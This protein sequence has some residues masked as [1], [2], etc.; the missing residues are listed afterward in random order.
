MFTILHI[1][2]LHRS[3]DDPISNDE[4]IS[5][6]RVDSHRY[7]S[8][9]PSVRRPD[10]IVVSGDL[11]QGV[12]L[13]V[14]NYLDEIRSQ[15]SVAEDFLRRLCDEFLNGDRS[16]IVIVPGNHDVDWNTSRVAMTP[17]VAGK[18][19]NY[20]AAFREDALYRW[21]WRTRQFYEIVDADVYANRLAAF[22][23]F[24]ERFYHNVS[25]IRPLRKD[26]A[27]GLFSLCD[28]RIGVAAFNSCEG[29]DCFAFH[30]SIKRQTIAASHL[31]LGKRAFDLWIGVWHHSIDGPPYRSDYMDIDTVRN[32]IGRGFRLGLF[33]HQHRSQAEARHIFLPDRNTMAVVGAGS[34]CAGRKELPTGTFRQYNL[35]ELSDDLKAARVHVRQMETAQLFSAAHLTYVGG[36]SYVDLKW[37]APVE[38]A[39]RQTAGPPK[40][41]EIVMESERL[42]K[43][44]QYDAALSLLVPVVHDLQPYG[45]SLFLDSAVGARRWGLIIEHAIPPKSIEELTAAIEAYDQTRRPQDAKALLEQYGPSVQM[46]ASLTRELTIRLSVRDKKQ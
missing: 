4:L 3:S 32:M 17:V 14:P 20:G 29:N 13:A 7:P 19:P 39:T 10:A 18:E 21:D 27:Y 23:E 9:N 46:P 41:H 33:G 42:V 25:V 40:H 11:I 35:I 30:G 16:R 5:S 1:S 36:K 38:I 8:E 37:E 24:V 28:G 34:L 45:R 15:Y 22:W 6:L 31:E 26:A 43:K 44:K 2:D 12:P